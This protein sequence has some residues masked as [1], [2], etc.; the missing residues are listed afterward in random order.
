MPLNASQKQKVREW[1]K[2][3]GVKPTCV[4][5]GASDWGAGELIS[6]PVLTPGGTQAADSH[7]PMVQLVCINCSHTMLYAAVPMGLP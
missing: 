7:V 2:S 4:S 1:M 5:C 3:R 6:A